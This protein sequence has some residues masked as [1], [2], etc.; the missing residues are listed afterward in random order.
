MTELALTK[1]RKQLEVYW[2][3]AQGVSKQ[4]FLENFTSTLQRR[5]ERE[6]KARAERLAEFQGHVGCK[7][8]YKD[9]IRTFDVL[10]LAQF[11][12]CLEADPEFILGDE[13]KVK[14]KDALAHHSTDPEIIAQWV[15][16]SV[17]SQ[18]INDFTLSVHGQDFE[19]LLDWL[20]WRQLPHAAE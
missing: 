10:T 2:D 12:R 1:K 15:D 9:L 11:E 19:C 14:F 17:D 5:L 7:L 20:H 3:A 8:L 6:A 4:D 16:D 18:D 13:H